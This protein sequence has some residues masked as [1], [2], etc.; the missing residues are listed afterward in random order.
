[1]NAQGI[2]G[3]HECHEAINEM[4]QLETRLQNLKENIYKMVL[5]AM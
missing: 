3:S 2:K 4:L 5:T 1:M